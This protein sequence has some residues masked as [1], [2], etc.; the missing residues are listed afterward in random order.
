MMD[1]DLTVFFDNDEHAV[2]A[3]FQGRYIAGIFDKEYYPIDIGEAEFE[4][5]EPR[6]LCAVCDLGYIKNGS[7]LKICDVDYTVR[8]KQPDGTGLV[9][10]VLTK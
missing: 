1:E 8:S 4:S 9:S 7:V 5:S 2:K 3:I 10:L 6:F